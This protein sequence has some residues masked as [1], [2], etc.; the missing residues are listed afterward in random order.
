MSFFE[1]PHT[2]TYDNDLGWLIAHVI[3]LSKQLENFINL[4]TIKYADPIAWNITTQY[5]AN[6]VVINPADGTAYI[7]TQPVP[8]GVLITNTDY[9]TP[10][11][12]YGES[13]ATLRLQIVPNDE[14]ANT[15]ASRAYVAGELLWKDG[16][17]WR[18][19]V[20]MPIGTA[21]IP[22][23]NI[24]NITM[25]EYADTHVKYH[26]TAYT[27]LADKTLAPGMFIV[28]RGYRTVGDGGA[29]LYKIVSAADGFTIDLDNGY[30]ARL[31]PFDNVV[32][33]MALGLAD[34]SDMYDKAFDILHLMLPGMSLY[35]PAGNYTLSDTLFIPNG[36][37]V[38]GDGPDSVIYFTGEYG[39]YGGGMVAGSGDAGF[40][41]LKLNHQETQSTIIQA[42]MLGAVGFSCIDF[43]LWAIKH[44]QAPVSSSAVNSVSGYFAEDLYSDSN[45]IVQCEAGSGKTI[46]N[47]RYRNINAPRAKVSFG[48]AGTV[49]HMTMENIRANLVGNVGGARNDLSVYKNIR[50]AHLHSGSTGVV[51][52]DEALIECANTNIA[53]GIYGEAC[54]LGGATTLINNMVVTGS[55]GDYDRSLTCGL[56]TIYLTNV[57]CSPDIAHGLFIGSPA[58]ASAVLYAANCDLLGEYLN[59]QHGYAVNCNAEFVD[60]DTFH[61]VYAGAV[62]AYTANWIATA[63]SAG[64]SLTET[65][66]ANKGKYILFLQL[67][68]SSNAAAG[69]LIRNLTGG[70]VI[71]AVSEALISFPITLSERTGLNLYIVGSG[72]TF[73][74]TDG[75]GMKLVR[76]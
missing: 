25:E 29:A 72:V 36:V 60:Y 11:F 44:Q 4:N 66:W 5:E 10:I 1:F 20:D 51:Q 23:A 30:K 76:I 37:T 46:S 31:V 40:R 6:T 43:S 50:C 48:G 14:K 71:R 24:E 41:K 18:V 68:K 45:Y 54:Y 2:R 62:P 9:W 53:S 21:F 22:D 39:Y 42:S 70:P 67:P 47:V 13:M 73:T 33:A 52:V 58:S 8:S 61:W 55:N 17:L 16:K 15:T 7:S 56:G 19:M 34:T 27:M 12:N 63:P 26:E 3:R 35:F 69:M 74:D 65:V 57:K 32:N 28:T 59:I 64:E 38:C 75:C 49:N